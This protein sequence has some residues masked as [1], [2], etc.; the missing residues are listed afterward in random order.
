MVKA[1]NPSFDQNQVESEFEEK[2]VAINRT[3]K[4]VKGGRRFG[5]SAIVVVGDKK[6]KV[7][8]GLG[9]AREVSDAIRKGSEIAKGGMV[10]FS[11]TPNTIPHAVMGKCGAAKVLLKP[12]AHGTGLIAGGSAR[13]VLEMVGVHDIL[14]KSMGSN[15]ATNLVKATLNGLSQL[16]NREQF[17]RLRS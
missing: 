17:N 14:A 6:G 5:F 10:K 16:R 8:I 7:G 9:K 12:A 11:I 15:C 4:V 13:A 2:V 1:Q 3:A